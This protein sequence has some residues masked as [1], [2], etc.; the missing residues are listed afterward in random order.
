MRRSIESSVLGTLC[1]AVLLLGACSEQRP[2]HAIR[3]NGDW[4]MQQGKYD[5]AISDYSEYL[6]RKPG[7]VAVRYDLGRAHLAAGECK[8]AME[9]LS[10]CVDV[11][12]DND[13]YAAALAAAL[14]DC[15]ESDR[16]TLFLRRRT[17]ERG[18]PADYI[19]LGQYANKLGHPDEALQAL[20]T[21]AR[22]DA[23]QTLAPQL[24]LADF[25][26]S[27]NDVPNQIRRLRMAL[28]L[29]P[30]NERVIEQLKAHGEVIGPTLALLPEEAQ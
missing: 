16:L 2:L 20:L 21:A 23:G 22:I 10:T 13:D 19:L 3:D 1:A 6:E 27:V 25:Y 14:F 12:P 29:S 15:K 18:T 4:A 11:R 17:A 28:Y 8:N 30:G 26:G 9:H 24:A 5:V 7:E